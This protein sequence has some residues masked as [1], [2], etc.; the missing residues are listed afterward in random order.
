LEL[1]ELREE[2]EKEGRKAA[3]IAK[4]QKSREY[5][6]NRLRQIQNQVKTGG[7][8]DG[9]RLFHLAWQKK[10]WEVRVQQFGG[11]PEGV[12]VAYSSFGDLLLIPVI[13]KEEAKKMGLKDGGFIDRDGREFWIP[14]EL[15]NKI[16]QI[17]GCVRWAQALTVNE[18]TTQFGVRLSNKE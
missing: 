1:S 6:K 9:Q 11:M 16:S 13:E 5:R 14:L 2:A 12:D 7:M 17:F 8:L 18:A 4:A 15:R 3:G 10:K